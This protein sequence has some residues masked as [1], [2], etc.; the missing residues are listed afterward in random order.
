MQ[1]AKI[2]LSILNQKSK[3]DKNYVFER[4][5]RNLFNPDFFFEAYAK[6]YAK[7]GN[8]T[9][10]IDEKTIDGF[11]IEIIK[12]LIKNLKEEK[13]YPKPVKRTYIPKKNGKKRA[14]GIPTFNDKLLQEVIRQI[15]EAIYE[16]TFDNNSHGFR[17][18]RSPHT[19]LVQIKKEFKGANWIIEGD[20]TKCF[21][22][23]NHDILLEILSRK[24]K[25][26]RFIELIRRYLKA[27]YFEFRKVHYSYSGTPQGSLIS[28]ILAN[29]YMNEFDN[30]MNEI[31][32][33]YTKGT[34][35][36]PNKEYRKLESK[37]LNARK[38]GNFELAEKILKEM[39]N[40]NSL[41][42]MDK[43]YI[44]VKYVRYCDDFIISVIGSKETATEI[45]ELISNFLLKN[46]KLELNLEK[47]LITNLRTSKALFLGYEIAKAK[48]NTKI[49]KYKNGT[50]SRSING[51]IQLLVPQKVITEKIK[52]FSEN[53]KSCAH[54]GRVNL[55]VL[56]IINQYNAEIRGL[57][58]YYR[59]AMNVSK[60]LYKFKFVHYTSLAKT[61]ARK[62][63][64]S[65]T[66]VIK[67]YGIDVPRKEG[68]GTIKVI[69]VTYY[70]KNEKQTLTYFN[71]SLKKIDE[72]I[73]N[74]N[75]K[76]NHYTKPSCQLIKRLNANKCELCGSNENIE[77]HHVRKLKD[78]KD[79]YKKRGKVTPNWVI[80]MSRLNRKTLIVCKKCHVKIHNGTK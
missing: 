6:I 71:D 27:G 10:G 73:K 19:A 2:L 24:I 74:L 20:I 72:P 38:N 66:K 49:T 1:K 47:T 8:M 52:K 35:R 36:E 15:L 11:N 57:Y 23:I 75:E 28:P 59:L 21:D 32:N 56:D 30:Y 65:V 4:V 43:N 42:Q 79:K 29:I 62:E 77:V 46:L 80:T 26:G 5:Y 13:Y 18:N 64:S 78:I 14:L 22:N 25:D 33:K 45:K 48:D 54:K 68:T 39:R 67:K 41:N 76:F 51:L 7:E 63:K 9:K 44:R 70:T 53:G 34:R 55:P 37:R 3:N 12:N 17:P 58:N 50:K 60:R 61:I 69:G 16:P 40:L 31:I